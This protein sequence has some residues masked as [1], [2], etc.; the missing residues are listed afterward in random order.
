MERADCSGGADQP[1]AFHPVR[2]GSWKLPSDTSRV[3]ITLPRG[4]QLG[5]V[6]IYYTP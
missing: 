5:R 3:Q 1:D 4:A 6:E 2:Y